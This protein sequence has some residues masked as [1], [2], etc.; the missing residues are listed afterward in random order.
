MDVDVLVEASSSPPPEPRL[1][2]W[3]LTDQYICTCIDWRLQRRADA[4]SAAAQRAPAA[5][6][7]RCVH[8]KHRALPTPRM[9]PQHAP[10]HACSA[11]SCELQA[12]SCHVMRRR[13]SWRLNTSGCVGNLSQSRTNRTCH[14]RSHSRAPS[15]G[16]FP[17]CGPS[18]GRSL[19]AGRPRA[20]PIHER[21]GPERRTA[22]CSA[23]CG[24]ARPAKRSGCRNDPRSRAKCACSSSSAELASTNGRGLFG[25][26]KMSLTS[27]R[28]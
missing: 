23:S 28:R 27:S 20:S 16:R 17:S 14:G 1:L 8:C 11:L 22:R 21:S 6:E 13:F 24:Q 5:H 10:P 12:P 19:S 7:R 26:Q 15:H 25:C 4:Q 2:D 9:R 3:R 18:H